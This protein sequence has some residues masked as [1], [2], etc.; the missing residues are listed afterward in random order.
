MRWLYL[1]FPDLYLHNLIQQ[2]PQ[3]A[4]QPL[5]IVAASG[6]THIQQCNDSARQHGVR[7]DM[8][9]ATAL[10]LSPG[11]QV[12]R[13]DP[14]LEQQLLDSRALWA[15]QFSAQVACDSG[16]DG[17]HGLW[18]EAA[19]MLRLFGGAERY[20]QQLQWSL[21]QQQ[22]VCHCGSGDTPLA[23]RLRANLLL[24]A[25][26][27]VD[28]LQALTLAQLQ[29]GQ[30]FTQDESIA[31]QRLGID[32]L[33]DILRLPFS[34]LATRFGKGLTQSLQRLL[35]Y[36]AHPLPAFEVPAVFEQGVQFIHEVSHANGLLFP[37][38]RLL[39]RLALYLQRQQSS[40]REL[41]LILQHRELTNSEW[42]IRFAHS[43][44]RQP[45]LLFLVRHFLEKQ[46]L[47]SPV[48]QLILRV[49]Q[50]QSRETTQH[51]L[52]MDSTQHSADSQQLLNRLGIRL[53][54]QQLLRLN[55][56]PDPRPEAALQLATALSDTSSTTHALRPDQGERPLWLLV[57][58][59]PC[60][61]PETVLAGPER[62]SSGWWDNSDVRRNY[63]LVEQQGQ[64][65]WVFYAPD[66]W[67][68]HG[69]FS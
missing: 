67:F 33:A 53:Q 15:T 44:Y 5:A 11:L 57:H 20:R 26:N 60:S 13:S 58:P 42:H 24:A 25:D 36:E 55:Y 21:Q 50:F 37:L 41:L 68:I 34:G 14:G 7:K 3:S 19:T 10:C 29:Q 59:I 9:L 54:P 32:T 6:Q 22:W 30:V 62:I 65:L 69:V 61:P 12:V 2:H 56:Q 39:Q 43:E 52:L 17:R 35:G 4:E 45:E 31:L 47:P 40:C 27:G 63:Y 48:Q 23:A 51:S 46:L 64:R 66:G 38:Q 28:D 8:P 49:D 16:H 18:L 1:L